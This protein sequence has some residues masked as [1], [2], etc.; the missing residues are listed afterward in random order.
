MNFTMPSSLLALGPLD[1]VYNVCGLYEVRCTCVCAHVCV[2]GGGGAH[3]HLQHSSLH[4]R[5][6]WLCVHIMDFQYQ[7]DQGWFGCPL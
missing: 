5:R 7:G 6:S 2:C 4:I 1:Q 3:S